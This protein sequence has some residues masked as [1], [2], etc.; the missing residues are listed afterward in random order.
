MPGTVA[1]FVVVL[2]AGK[3]SLYRVCHNPISLFLVPGSNLGH[4]RSGW[5]C[6][7]VTTIVV[8]HAAAVPNRMGKE[9]D[10][11][12][13][14]SYADNP[15]LMR[16]PLRFGCARTVVIKSKGSDV[17]NA[18]AYCVTWISD[19]VALGEYRFVK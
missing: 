3:P 14:N 17:I 15:D 7:G 10:V 19:P 18:W 4:L 9:D 13:V 5:P 8:D 2:A 16:L 11:C 6:A 1:S 12:A